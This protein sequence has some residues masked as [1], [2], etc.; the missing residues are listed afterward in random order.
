LDG[1]LDQDLEKFTGHIY[2][3]KGV[4]SF[5]MLGL[6]NSYFKGDRDLQK[7]EGNE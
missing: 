4:A 6:T 2:E 3:Y 7:V 1:D 5:E